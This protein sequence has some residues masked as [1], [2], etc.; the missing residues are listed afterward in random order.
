MAEDCCLG[1]MDIS[2]TS[3]PLL[4]PLLPFPLRPEQQQPLR[5]YA[6]V[7]VLIVARAA[8]GPPP[9][10]GPEASPIRRL[11]TDPKARGRKPLES[12]ENQLL[13]F[14]MIF[15]LSYIEDAIQ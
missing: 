4:S 11:I 13:L 5:T 2:P 9:V 7:S 14:R 6:E 10:H 15:V 1:T 12:I 8:L 3:P